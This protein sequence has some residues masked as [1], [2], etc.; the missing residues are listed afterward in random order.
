M[1]SLAGKIVVVTGASSGIGAAAA[2][3]LAHAGATVAVVGR[4]GP[5]TAAVAAACGNDAVPFVA[6]MASLAGVRDLA[7][8]LG[9]AFP[10]IDVLANNAGFI[11]A[12]KELTV[13]GIE[14]TFAVNHV[15]A[16]LLTRLLDSNLRASA[17]GRVVTTS[18]SAHST[19]SLTRPFEPTAKWTSWGAYGDS[20]LANIAFTA[21]L[22]RRLQ[23]STVTAHCFHPGVVHTGFGRDKNVLALLQRAVGRFFLLSSEQGAD[24]L[25]FLASSADAV[26]TP[27]RYWRKRRVV[28]PAAAGQDQVAAS[29]LWDRTEALIA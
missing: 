21:E 13:D 22:N 5:R 1:D 16:F 14:T 29:V 3:A 20:K 28:T 24:T 19:G 23:G 12:D 11:A 15:A 27:G 25:V 10:V 18:S 26:D 9:S 17:E 6:D 4:D 2:K 7:Q 8:R